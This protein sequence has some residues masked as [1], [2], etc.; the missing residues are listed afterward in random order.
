M[1]PKKKAQEQPG[2]AIGQ[3]SLFEIPA[4][5]KSQQPQRKKGAAPR[6]KSKENQPDLFQ[7]EKSQEIKKPGGI[8]PGGEIFNVGDT[9]DFDV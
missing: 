7:E 4:A 6:Q 1:S 8:K 5:A 2:E 9:I 3:A